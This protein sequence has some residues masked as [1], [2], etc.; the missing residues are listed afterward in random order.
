[1][2]EIHEIHLLRIKWYEMIV[3]FELTSMIK[4]YN[5]A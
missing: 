5:S 3:K 4:I 2:D 1:M